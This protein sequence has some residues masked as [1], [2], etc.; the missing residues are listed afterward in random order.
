M[1]INEFLDA[2]YLKTAR[3]AGLSEKENLHK[4]LQLTEE[5]I[6]NEYKLIMVRARHIGNVK[7]ALAVVKSPVLIGTVIDFPEGNSTTEEKLQE[8]QKAMYAG[9]HELDFVLN[10]NAFKAGD[11]SLL[12]DEI[13]QC[14]AL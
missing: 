14:T 4:V 12:T 6:A 7:T 8:A 11:I 10:Y 9:A 5:A 13:T 2:T 3:Q 1:K